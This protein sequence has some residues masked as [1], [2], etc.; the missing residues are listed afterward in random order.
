VEMWDE[1]HGIE[2]HTMSQNIGG[3]T[4]RT[5]SYGPTVRKDERIFLSNIGTFHVSSLDSSSFLI[6]IIFWCVHP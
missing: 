4:K 3:R 5:A 2:S 6:S 1:S